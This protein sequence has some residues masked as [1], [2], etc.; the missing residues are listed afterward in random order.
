M[1]K[2]RSL[3]FALKA[4]LSALCL[5]MLLFTACSNPLSPAAAKDDAVERA[6]IDPATYSGVVIFYKGA[7]APNIWIW[8]L[9]GNAISANMGYSWSTKP[10]MTA[11]SAHP[12]W[13]F[14]AIPS[15]YLSGKNLVMKF[16]GGGDIARGS[17]KTG[18]YT[19][20][21]A[22][23]SDTFP[24]VVLPDITIYY[25]GASAPTIWI[26]EPTGNALS[27]LMGYSWATK[28]TMAACAD[29]PGWYSFTVP[30]A[31]R[32]GA[33]LSMKFNGG[34][35]IARGSANSGWYDSISSIWTDSYPGDDDDDDDDTTDVTIYYRASSAPSIWIWEL[36]ANAISALMGFSWSSQ[37]S[38][39]P[40]SGYAGWYSYTIPATYLSGANLVMKFNSGAPGPAATAA[41]PP[42]RSQ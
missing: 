39:S 25:K 20:S 10:T 40:A 36:N 8:E 12:G 27:T 26:W 2:G 19:S 1:K 22:T 4:G 28:P 3:G 34:A 6:T 7:S 42:S 21:K 23:W 37:P 30:G 41:A 5:C 29:Y 35:D 14:F 13:Y 31:F 9:A 11:D 18:Y 33:N 16:N 15:T 38:M 24:D 32:T 17:A